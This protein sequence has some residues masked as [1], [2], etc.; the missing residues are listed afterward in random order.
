MSP[1]LTAAPR[2]SI[3]IPIHNEADC[4]ESEVAELLGE[5]EARGLEYELIL[6]ENGSTDATV[7]VAKRLAADNPHIRPLHLPIPDYGAAMRAGFGM[8]EGQAVVNF[9]IDFY[10]VDFMERAAHYLD[11]YGIVVGSKLIFGSEDRRSWFRRRVSWVFTAFLRILFDRKID[12]THGMK[13]VRRDV[14]DRF[15]PRTVM[16]KDLFDTELVLRA[17]RGGIEVR[18]IPVV[19]EEKRKPRLSIFRRIPRAIFGMLR[20]RVLFWKERFL[21][22]GRE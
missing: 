2:F 1:S 19:V 9:D 7:E 18:A 4:L 13:V 5:V 20:L 6:A 14:V 10:D 3:V 8:A 16:T 22:A 12:D 17:R 21:G 15:L 11:E